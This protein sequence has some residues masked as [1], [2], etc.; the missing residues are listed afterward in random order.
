MPANK[1]KLYLGN[2]NALR[3]WGFAP[4]YVE[5]MW[6]MLQHHEADDYVVGT[7]RSYTVRDFVQRAFAYA[8]LEL[9]WVGAGITERG[10]V[11]KTHDR[12]QTVTKPGDC[13]VE[14]DPRYFRPTEVEHLQADITKARE[15]L[16]WQ[17]RVTFDELVQIMVDYDLQFAGLEPIGHG[18]Q[19]NNDKHFEYTHH[20]LS[21]QQH[22]NEN[23]L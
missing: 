18:L 6:L 2:L 20:D 17:P 23:Y 4:E 11:S 22:V 21:F 1:K 14:V 5:M 9:E 13:L 8:G 16:C 12:W 15:K 3:D 10:V 7:G 19:V